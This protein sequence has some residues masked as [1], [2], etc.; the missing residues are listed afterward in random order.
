[1]MFCGRP[2]S[3]VQMSNLYC[4]GVSAFTSRKVRRTMIPVR[5]PEKTTRQSVFLKGE[6]RFRLGGNCA[7][8]LT[9]FDGKALTEPILLRTSATIHRACCPWSERSEEALLMNMQP[10]LGT[11]SALVALRKHS[12]R[13]LSR[14]RKPHAL[15]NYERPNCKPA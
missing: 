10:G 4:L 2:F 12:A 13:P 5:Q 9:P 6:T 15:R 8:F 3:A 1:M 11:R 7:G 14:Y